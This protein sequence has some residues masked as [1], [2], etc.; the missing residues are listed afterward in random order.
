MKF[1]IMNFL[2]VAV[3]ASSVL[4][5]S[6]DAKVCLMMYQLADNN[7]EYFI[8][9]DYSELSAS[10]LIAD[11]NIR[12]WVYYDALN[13]GG[14]NLPNTVDAAG[15]PLTGL[16]TGSRYMTYDPGFGKFKVDTVL[17]GEQ[18]SDA[19]A[20]MQTFLERALDDCISNGHDSLMAV[21][22][23]HAGGF[24]GYGGDENGRRKL[25]QTNSQ[26]AAAVKNA[27]ANTP[28][29]PGK[30]EVIGFDA[31]N[32]QALEAADDYTGVAQYLLASEALEPGHGWSYTY[33]SDA[34][35]ALD[36]ANQVVSEFLART[37]GGNFHLSPKTLAVLD[38]A[39]FETFLASFETFFGGLLS[40]LQ[41]GD[42][43]AHSFIARAR[44]SAVAF[45][46]ILDATGER[47]PASLD[48][49]SFFTQFN[50]LCNPGGDVGTSLQTT[51]SLYADMFE[52]AGIGL[53]T[54]LGTGMHLVWPIQGI[55][56]ANVQLFNTILFENPNYVTLSAPN[57]RAFLQWYLPSTTPATTDYT[58][59]VCSQSAQPP[60]VMA[61]S[62][63]LILDDIATVDD[64]A[65]TF[66]VVTNIAP[67]V[68][69]MTVEY[70]IDLSTPLKSFLSERGYTPTDDEY[71][72]L[73]GGDVAGFYEGSTFQA[74]WDQK[75]YFLNIS[76]TSTFEALYVHD[77]GGGAKS[78]PVMYFPEET[79][80][81]AAD[82]QFLDYLF[83]DFDFWLAKGAKYSFLTFSTDDAEGRVNDNLILFTS[84]GDNG[85][86]E[87]RMEDGGL[88]MPLIYVDAYIQGNRL[89][90]L[91][92]GFNQTII[93][94]SADLEYNI[95]TTTLDQVFGRI[96]D[97]DAVV[98]SM[99]A[100]NDGEPDR[101]AEV[102][103]YDVVRQSRSGDAPPAFTSSPASGTMTSE[104][105]GGSTST[106]SET[107]DGENAAGEASS[108]SVVFWFKNT[109]AAFAIA[110]GVLSALWCF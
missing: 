3:M 72:L 54:A 38:L 12:T 7:L 99:Y 6:A 85:Y 71:L 22:S 62:N 80:G 16:F 2:A 66:H 56:L 83:F 27:L 28:G 57:Y 75:F 104:P 59:T 65:K 87:K 76:S 5:P 64:A 43:T 30:L 95:L 52:V 53:G 34:R 29:A 106:G 33:L 60:M 101:E 48:I 49:G 98:I 44:A 47:S 23:S 70:S 90:V 81:A 67:A 74:S 92:G 82:L 40:S 55:Y 51:R 14:D 1:G 11:E 37:Q 103:Y 24:A 15:Q 63:A 94:W 19:V 77:Q 35:S 96:P 10:P 110:T 42:V 107:T 109:Q 89:E 45:E 39:K 18:N 4:L 20:T 13:Q 17:A 9:Q 100:K 91:P 21:F 88:I 68:T 73:K 93:D 61:D 79:R 32:M 84:N 26:I 105:T 108:S 58:N 46:G 41:G 102:R 8:R 97:T 25:L 36:L 86:A 69:Q 50:S 78:I 31:C